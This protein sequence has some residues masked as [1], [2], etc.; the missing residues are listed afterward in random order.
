MAVM[1]ALAIGSVIAG[2]AISAAGNLR[3]G[4]AAQEAAESEAKREEFNAGVAE[5]QAQDAIARGRQEESTLRAGVRQLLGSQ[6]AAVASSGIE[7]G[8][9]SASDVAADTAFRAELDAQR[10]R[11]N[12]A[13]EAWGYEVEADDRRMAADVARRGGQAARSAGRWNAAGTIVAGG[14][15]L[16]M[17][18]YGFERATTRRAG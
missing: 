8:R 10:L 14:S 7:V 13:R 18:R 3:Q 4:R 1:T 6:R 12:A 9:G 11:Q 5:L 2:T 16:L 15:S 17:Q